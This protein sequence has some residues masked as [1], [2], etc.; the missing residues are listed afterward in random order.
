[1]PAPSVFRLAITPRWIA[2]G[3]IA[4]LF[5]L[6]ALG[7]GRWQWDRTQDIVQ[8]ERVSQSQ[9]VAIEDV[10]TV[11]E[12]FDNPVIGR[13][14]F[15]DGEYVADVQTPVLFR[16]VG[17]GQP[18]VWIL[19]PLT[20]SDGSA[21]AVLRGWAPSAAEAPVPA[22]AVQ[23]RGIWHPNE[24]FYRDEVFNTD[25]VVAISSERLRE[26]WN[27]PLR[28][29]FIMLTEQ[30]PTSD[31]A[32]V[33]QTVQTANVPFP[34]QNLFYAVQWLVF[35]AFAVFVYVRWL[36]MEARQ[37]VESAASD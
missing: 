10:T 2:L 12:D 24:R 21:I 33:P 6:A 30:Q 4:L 31:L 3:L 32:L 16:S 37:R 36:R 27:L 18:G 11:G 9:A 22:G 8:A 14:V 7:L 25:G 17:D 20:L 28:P 29:G 34:I 23:V 19:T 15:A 1:M 35:A 5:G 26:R 13:P